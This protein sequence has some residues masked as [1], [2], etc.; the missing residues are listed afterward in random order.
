MKKFNL[1]VACIIATLF[2]TI[3]IIGCKKIT[4]E[5]AAPLNSEQEI[6]NVTNA[7]ISE[8]QAEAA[9]NDIYDNVMG[10]QGNNVG[11]A[12]GVGIFKA[13]EGDN[14]RTD[15]FN[16]PPCVKI[17]VDQPSPTGYPKTVTIDFGANGCTTA[18]RHMRKGKIIT[19]YSNRLDMAGAT[20]TTTFE[21]YYMDSIKVEGTHTISNQSSA[22][23]K[24]YTVKITDGKVTQPNGDY[25]EY[26]KDHTNAQT[27]G[28]NTIS[29]ADDVFEI[30]GRSNGAF[31]MG[32]DAAKTW[33]STINE[34]LVRKFTCPWFLTGKLTITRTSGQTAAIDYAPTNNGSCDKKASVTINGETKIVNIDKWF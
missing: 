23:V 33:S 2:A 25:I 8:G 28:G 29:P 7:S 22:T 20:A 11:T 13:N 31:K 27:Q 17:I 1:L 4:E 16:L 34:P 15:T 3:V 24:K 32:A 21:N 19:V 18:G 6:T 30:T 14:I 9:F 10:Y 26:S 12:T 5:G